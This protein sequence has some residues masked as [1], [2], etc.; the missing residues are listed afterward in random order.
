[1]KTPDYYINFAKE[2]FEREKMEEMQIWGGEPFLAMHRAYY[3]IEECIKYFPNFSKLMVSTNMVSEQ[4][5]KEFW[6]LINTFGKYPNRKFEFRLQL[7]CDGPTKINDAN[8]GQGVTEKIEQVFKTLVDESA[9]KVPENV[10]IKAHMKPTL[11]SKSISELQT[12]ELVL[13]YFKFFETFYGYW[14]EH[15]N[16]RFLFSLPIPNTACPSPHTQQDG[17][18]FA[19]YCRLTREIE[20][21]KTLKY[22]KNITSFVRKV[23]TSTAILS[24]KCRGHCGNGRSTIGLLPDDM[25]SCCHNGFV[26]MLSE[27]KKNVMEN[28]S[29]HMDNVVLEKGIF[30]NQHNSLIFKKDSEKFE[31]YQEKL[32]EF[33]NT[34]STIKIT[35][36]ASLVLLLAR[37][38]Q[39]D[40]KYCDKEEAIRGAIFVLGST[41]YCVRDNL[42]VTGSIYMYPLGLIKLLL[43]GA[44]EYIETKENGNVNISGR[45]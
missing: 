44:R 31:L 43:N 2:M 6:G 27:Y 19:N 45:K 1:M 15:K 20:K 18:N 22:Y 36:V 28:N 10:T 38:G 24:N 12:K 29:T 7:S 41:A 4:F 14:F 30:T 23:D 32:E 9:Y 37:N 21:D 35:N 34:N 13:D 16:D 42:G 8:R 17:I 39:I 3:T 11:D 33:Y 26:D 5:F 40:K 25:I